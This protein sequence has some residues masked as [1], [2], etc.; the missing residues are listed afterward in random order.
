M[1]EEKKEKKKEQVE[2]DED[3]EEASIF[4]S[5]M[6]PLV[7]SR[8]YLYSVCP[9]LSQSVVTQFHHRLNHV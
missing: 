2:E 5:M 6:D 7:L 1:E 9:I 3:E 4:S 8:L